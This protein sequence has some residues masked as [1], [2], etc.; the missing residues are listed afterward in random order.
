MDLWRSRWSLQT[1]EEENVLMP[2]LLIDPLADAT[3]EEDKPENKV[4][5]VRLYLY[6]QFSPKSLADE[7]S[8]CDFK[9]MGFEAELEQQDSGDSTLVETTIML[10]PVG[11]RES[12]SP[13]EII[14]K[15]SEVFSK[16]A[17]LSPC[18]DLLSVDQ[19][20]KA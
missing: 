6:Q 2:G 15:L 17:E 9:E 4:G 1:S 8:G 14:P 19:G 16:L 5:T 7:L 11:E 12:W 10:K 13:R 20:K 3:P 18:V